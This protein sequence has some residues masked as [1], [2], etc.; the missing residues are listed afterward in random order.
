[1][2]DISID[3]QALFEQTYTQAPIGIALVAIDGTWIKVNSSFCAMLGYTE[4]EL[5]ELTRQDITHPDD[6]M[7]DKQH[8]TTLIGAKSR[9]HKWEKRYL[10]KNGQVKWVSKYVSLVCSDCNEPMYYIAYVTDISTQK[11]SEIQMR[12]AESMYTLICDNAI[13]IISYMSPEGITEYCSPSLKDILGYDPDEWIGKNNFQYYHPDDIQALKSRV[14]TDNDVYTYRVRHKDGYYIWFETSTKIIRD[15]SGHIHKILGI[16]RDITERKKFEESFV[17]AQRIALLGSWEWDIQTDKISFSDQIYEIFGLDK[18]GPLRNDFLFLLHPEDQKRFVQLRE[19]ALE[20]EPFSSEFRHIRQDG[21]VKHV[22][23]RGHVMFDDNGKAL[24]MYGTTQDVTELKTAQI[25]LEETI[26]RYTSLKKYNHDAIISLDLDGNVINTNAVAEGMT[27][28]PGS[29]ISGMSISKFI[30]EEYR[31]RILTDEANHAI[32][33][34]EINHIR[35]KDGHVTEVLTTIAP[36]IINKQTRGYYIIAKDITDQKNLL[37]AKEAAERT[38]KAKS[39]FLA[40]MSHEIR[41]PM[42]GVI[43][44]TDLLLETTE[45]N[46]EQKEYVQMISKSGNTLL[47]IINDIL[48]FSKIESGRAIVITEPFNLRTLVFETLDVFRLKTKEKNLDTQISISP[49]IPQTLYGDSNRLKQVLMNLIGNA[50]KFTERGGITIEIE[51]LDQGYGNIHLQF[52]ISDTGMGIPEDK[53]EYLFE[54]F[55]QIDN[56]MTRKSEGTGLGLAISKK[57]VEIMGGEIHAV[58]KDEPGATFVFTAYFQKENRQGNDLLKGP[59]EEKRTAAKPLSIL[60]AED[61][62][63]NQ[64][65]LTRM[66]EKIGHQADLAENGSE[67]IDKLK[68][69]NYDLVFMDIQMPVMNG[70]ETCREIKSRFPAEKWPYIVAVTANALRGDQEVCMEAGMDD[71]ISK[72]IKME[73]LSEVLEKFHNFRKTP[74]HE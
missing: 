48:D 62:K 30:G 17:E 59:L 16:G 66:L 42:N 73:N 24:K 67:V 60:I 33:E 34:R 32:I 71:Y 64:M 19:K 41:T 49:G 36:I 50:V 44:M 26:E 28:Y 9:Q 13:D 70:L 18:Q 52:T 10:T 45:L 55:T 27:G 74:I 35:H 8:M 68:V 51:D 22:H 58:Q 43:G 14:F 69:F 57:I 47:A 1:M 23:I 72:P 21:S 53:L 4:T 6:V 63:V 40:I 39:E 11:E 2:N 20:G 31:D 54:P 46:E 37:I 65:V 15:E 5:M 3:H 25:K 7:A 61:N 56:F 12:E 38:N 29:V